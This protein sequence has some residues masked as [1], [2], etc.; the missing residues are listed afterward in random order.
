[1]IWHRVVGRQP[2]LPSPLCPVVQA[3]ER[4][5][6]ERTERDVQQIRRR[7]VVR[8]EKRTLVG[9]LPQVVRMVVVHVVRRVRLGPSVGVVVVVGRSRGEMVRRV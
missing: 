1:M 7:W 4:V 5:A 6:P 3:E 2:L 8:Q 9:V